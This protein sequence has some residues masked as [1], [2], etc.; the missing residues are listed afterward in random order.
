MTIA[1]KNVERFKV[2]YVND[3]NMIYIDPNDMDRAK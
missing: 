2:E 1:S 3:I